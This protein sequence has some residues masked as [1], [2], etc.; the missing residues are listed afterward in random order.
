MCEGRIILEETQKLKREIH[1][2]VWTMV[3]LKRCWLC[4]SRYYINVE[5]C[6]CISASEYQAKDRSVLE[7]FRSRRA[8]Y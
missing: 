6:Q 7:R 4:I 3:P 8:V 1:K 2:E 5:P